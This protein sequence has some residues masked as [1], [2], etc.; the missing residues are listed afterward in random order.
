MQNLHQ[1]GECDEAISG[2][3]QRVF[4]HPKLVLGSHERRIL[5]ALDK[6]E[7]DDGC[8]GNTAEQTD[9]I[10][11][12]SSIVECEDKS[13]NVLYDGTE[14]EGNRYRKEDTDDDG[15]GF[16]CI[17]QVAES[18]HA[19]FV[20]GNL[21]ERKHESTSKEFEYH[22]DGGG[23]RHPEGVEDVQQDYVSHHDCQKDAHQFLKV[24]VFGLEDA[25]PGNFHHAVTEGS[26]E[27]YADG[28]NCNDEFERSGLG[29]DGR[30]EKVHSVVADTY[31]QVE[32]GEQEK[33]YYDS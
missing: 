27:E 3:H 31:Y 23:S 18:Q 30:V 7:I 24:E 21:D 1:D 8:S 26:S 33:E 22:R 5:Q 32:D 16:F 6:H 10:F 15:Q 19:G 11:K 17:Q 13:G 20:H 2:E 12:S 29:A 14:E 28:G 4:L 25:V 9:G